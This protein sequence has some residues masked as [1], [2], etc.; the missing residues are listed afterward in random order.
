M[1][2]YSAGDILTVYNSPR[3]KNVQM[4]ILE[5]TAEYL[6]Y[7]PS[8]GHLLCQY[9]GTTFEFWMRESDIDK[10]IEQAKQHQ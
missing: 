7:R 3:K 6:P 5:I 8:E 10:E 9:V 4:R 2:K 1:P